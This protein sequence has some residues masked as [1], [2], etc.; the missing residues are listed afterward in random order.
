MQTFK[1]K[2]LKL[3]AL[4]LLQEVSKNLH[5]APFYCV[6]ADETTDISNH[7]QVVRWL[8]ECMAHGLACMRLSRN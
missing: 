6:L 3:M 1:M 4:Q 7:E 8:D 2:F 5:S